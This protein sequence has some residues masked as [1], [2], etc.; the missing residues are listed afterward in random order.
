MSRACIVLV[1]SAGLL[2]ASIPEA[3]AARVTDVADAFDGD[4]VYDANLFITFL[5]NYRWAKVTKEFYTN[6]GIADGRDLKITEAGNQMLLDVELGL[7]KDLSFNL[8]LPIAFSQKFGAKFAGGVS[9]SKSELHQAWFVG[10]LDADPFKSEH[11]AGVGDMHIG[12]KWAPFNCERENEEWWP[13]WML[14][15]DVMLPSGDP[16]D[17]SDDFYNRFTGSSKKSGL[18]VGQGFAEMTFGTALS[19]RFKYFDP[20]VGFHYTLP[21]LTARSAIKK[22]LDRSM[23]NNEWNGVDTDV[24]PDGRIDRWDRQSAYDDGAH[25]GTMHWENDP[26]NTDADKQPYPSDDAADNVR[27]HGRPE[28]C[29]PAQP[30]T[31]EWSGA[32]LDRIRD[33]ILLPH[34]FG[35]MLGMEIIAWEVPDKNQ[36]FAIDVGFNAEMFTEGVTLNEL[37][38]LLNKPT[39]TE[40]YAHFEG[41]FFFSVQAAQ[42]VY[43]RAGA[44]L[45]HDTEHFLTYADEASNRFNGPGGEDLPD[46]YFDKRLDSVG[47]RVR[48]AETFLFTWSVTGAVT[49]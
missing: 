38:D 45:G 30:S 20:Y 12:L 42:Y 5:Q 48:V 9:T 41:H 33:N 4:D 17:P 47:Q 18:G 40:Q 32:Q 16:W 46:A 3:R 23:R 2:L 21:I 35:M 15:Y 29:D 39:Y 8:Q 36:K 19:K 37:S 6:L 27:P 14:Y 13:T 28:G 34:H 22:N 1:L 31:C 26:N 49:F 11:A 10:D 7:Y 24:P 25:F 43:F 44:T